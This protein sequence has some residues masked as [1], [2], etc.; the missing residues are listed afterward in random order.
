MHVSRRERGARCFSECLRAKEQQGD[1]TQGDRE[2]EQMTES[3][4]NNYGAIIII[5]AS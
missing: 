1:I 2:V 4:Y 5:R 3:C